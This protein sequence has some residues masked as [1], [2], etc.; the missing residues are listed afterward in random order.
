MKSSSSLNIL[1]LTIKDLSK[2]ISS[3]DISPV[4]LVEAIWERIA[5]LNPKL[6]AFITIL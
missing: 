5:K 1:N 3:G 4:D 6:N 2:H